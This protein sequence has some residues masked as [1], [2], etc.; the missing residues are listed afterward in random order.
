[1]A[2]IIRAKLE[3]MPSVVWAGGV[4]MTPAFSMKIANRSELDMNAFAAFLVESDE[5]I[6]TLS[7]LISG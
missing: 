1:M 6:P 4:A 2:H 7:T 3:F 5:D